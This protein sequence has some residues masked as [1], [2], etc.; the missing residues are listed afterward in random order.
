MMQ[1]L[2]RIPAIFWHPELHIHKNRSLWQED[3]VRQGL[4]IFYNHLNDLESQEQDGTVSRVT[5]INT[6]LAARQLR[7]SWT[8]RKDEGFIRAIQKVA[9]LAKKYGFSKLWKAGYYDTMLRRLEEICEADPELATRH[10][11]GRCGRAI[12]N[13]VSVRRGIGPVCWHKGASR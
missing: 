5:V 8:L 13:E 6:I 9:Q 3:E 4:D 12:W 11:C 10:H 1:S 7:N 2:V